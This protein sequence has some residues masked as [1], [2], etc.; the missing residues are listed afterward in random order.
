MKLLR[1]LKH[2][3][4]EF[5]MR[6]DTSIVSIRSD[7]GKEFGNQHFES[8]CEE[9]GI[10]HNFSC[11][12]TPQQNGVVERRNRSLQE[13]A[14]AMLCENDLPKF[15]WVEAVSA[16]CYVLNR[17]LVRPILKKM[18]YELWSEI[19][20]TLHSLLEYIGNATEF[21]IDFSVTK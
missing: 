17:T 6:K 4:K 8:F 13:M 21:A 5:K 11:P 14:R 10:S 1:C 3:A 7:Y 2:F 18:P 12:R 16:A 20:L 15:L 19:K 9:N